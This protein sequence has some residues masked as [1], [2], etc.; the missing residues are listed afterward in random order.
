[1]NLQEGERN[2]K[3][4]SLERNSTVHSYSVFLLR[5][6]TPWGNRD[7]TMKDEEREGSKGRITSFGGIEGE[8][9]VIGNVVARVSMVRNL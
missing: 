6:Q 8:V 9:V 2:I 1:M 3:L 5:K 7:V 4:L